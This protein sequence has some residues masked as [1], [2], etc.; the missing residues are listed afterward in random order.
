MYRITDMKP[1]NFVSD[2]GS[3]ETWMPIYSNHFRFLD[4]FRS[5]T[6]STRPTFFFNLTI[7]NI[8]IIYYLNMLTDIYMYKWTLIRLMQLYQHII[9]LNTIKSV[10]EQTYPNIEIIVINDRSTEQDYYNY[11]W[12]ANSVTIIH[13]EKNTRELFGFPC[14]GYVRNAGIDASTGKSNSILL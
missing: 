12:S 2:A 10:K 13:L 5:S 3:R 7:F 11:N 1:S 9:D 6:L 4:Q 8:N 14:A